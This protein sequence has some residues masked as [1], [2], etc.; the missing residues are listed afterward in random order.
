VIVHFVDVGG[1][2]DHHCLNFIFITINHPT[3][4]SCTKPFFFCRKFSV[5]NQIY[6][7]FSHRKHSY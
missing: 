1:I 7:R 5:F 2:D 6:H 4:K 3:Q